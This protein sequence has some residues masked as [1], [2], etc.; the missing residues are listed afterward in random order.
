MLVQPDVNSKVIVPVLMSIESSL[1]DLLHI[2]VE[3]GQMYVLSVPFISMGIGAIIYV[4]GDYNGKIFLDMGPKAAIKITEL[5]LREKVTKFDKLVQSTI[6]ELVNVIAGKIATAIGEFS[7]VNIS[8][9]K[10]ISKYT[11]NE[12]TTKRNIA[13]I[14]M[15]FDKY[16]LNVS[17]FIL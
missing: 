5:F 9:P 7:N 4:S 3:R 13:L 8:T 16:I 2:E 15:G 11:K 1:N 17:F 14:P 12:D 6:G 10:I